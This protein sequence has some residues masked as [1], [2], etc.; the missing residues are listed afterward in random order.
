MILIQNKEL[1]QGWSMKTRFGQRTT[2]AL[3]LRN[4]KIQ[5]FWS[6]EALYRFLAELNVDLNEG[7]SE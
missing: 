2:Y 3:H 6:E 4:F 5:T 1:G 7:K